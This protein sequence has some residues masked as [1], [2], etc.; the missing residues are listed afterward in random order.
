ILT[1]STA[2]LLLSKELPC[3]IPRRTEERKSESVH[4][5]QSGCSQC[6]HC[7]KK[8]AGV[9]KD[10]PELT[11]TVVAQQSQKKRQCPTVCCEKVLKK[12]VK[13]LRTRAPEIS[14]L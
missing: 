6:G 5:C 3:S 2:C 8:G 10:I 4:G 11:D 12:E 9:K 13:K 1:Q 7:K 14:V